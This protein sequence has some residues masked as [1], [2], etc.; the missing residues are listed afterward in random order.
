M[1]PDADDEAVKASFLKPHGVTPE[2][3]CKRRIRSMGFS[4]GVLTIRAF[5]M[6]SKGFFYQFTY[7]SVL[8]MWAT[9][10]LL[11]LAHIMNDDFHKQIYT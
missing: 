11:S 5:G 3:L 4:L 8:S 7:W 9:F 1:F 6:I 2:T 10:T